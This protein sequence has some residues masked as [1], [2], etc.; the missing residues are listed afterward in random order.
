ML[1][2]RI[3]KQKGRGMKQLWLH[4]KFYHGICPVGLKKIKET[5]FRITNV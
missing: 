2:H 5:S 4:L 1:A 3:M